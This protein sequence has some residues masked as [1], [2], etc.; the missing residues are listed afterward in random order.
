MGC[1]SNYLNKSLAP[2]CENPIFAGLEDEAILINATDISSVA[3]TGLP[4]QKVIMLKGYAKGFPVQ[5]GGAVPFGGTSV[6]MEKS[7]Y[8]V[9]SA[10][11]F[12]F[13]F[14]N[15]GAESALITEML[16]NGRFVAIVENKNKGIGGDNA[17]II[18][19]L[20]KPLTVSSVNKDYTNDANESATIVTMTTAEQRFENYLFNGNYT[21]TKDVFNNYKQLSQ[22]L[23]YGVQCGV[24]FSGNTIDLEAE[25][26]VLK[27]GT[28]DS[29][30]DKIHVLVFNKADGGSFETFVFTRSNTG[31]TISFTFPSAVNFS[32]L[33][34]WIKV[35][36]ADGRREGIMRQVEI[37]E[38]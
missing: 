23:G 36:S 24:M 8:S 12:T 34:V 22:N 14:Q 9:K 33:S 21:D 17:F 20:D 2:N 37:N 13:A 11:T 19:G 1:L 3:V 7:D 15:A 31:A 30:T 26:I 29:P 35:V 10:K 16:M 4:N 25:M 38:F 27:S 6:A 28:A 32:D 18:I 5:V